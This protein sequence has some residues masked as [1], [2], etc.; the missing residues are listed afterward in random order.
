MSPHQGQHQRRCAAVLRVSAWKGEAELAALANDA[1]YRD[2]AVHL[3]DQ[4][5]GDEQSD[6]G[7]YVARADHLVDLAESREQTGHILL[8]NT[9][10]VVN[11]RDL[12]GVRKDEATH[13][14]LRTLWR[15]LHAVI[16]Q[17]GQHLLHAIGISQHQRQVWW[18][19]ETHHLAA[20]LLLNLRHGGLDK[21]KQ[22]HTAHGPPQRPAP[23]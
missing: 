5:L 3:L 14:D 18:D 16:H 15:I 12:H 10:A 7:A 9:Q 8:T 6:A 11:Y 17:A 4:L 21:I 1:M 2:C 22:L 13:L 20:V 23:N 19:V